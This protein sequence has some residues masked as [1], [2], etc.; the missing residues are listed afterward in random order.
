MKKSVERV[1]EWHFGVIFSALVLVAAVGVY[2]GERRQAEVDFRKCPLC[3]E[4]SR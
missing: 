2:W 3:G 1:K 4:I